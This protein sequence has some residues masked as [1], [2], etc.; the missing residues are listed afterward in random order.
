MEI[1]FCEFGVCF[2]AEVCVG[3]FGPKWGKFVD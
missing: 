3:G 2:R 1:G